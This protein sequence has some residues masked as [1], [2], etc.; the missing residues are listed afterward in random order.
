MSHKI[1][2][3][4]D[5]EAVCKDISRYLSTK[6]YDV[7]TANNGID[8]ISKASADKPDLILLD[9]NMPQMNGIECLRKI[10]ELNKD[11][12]VIMATV[13]TD[14][15]IAKEAINSGALDYITKPFDL[16]TLQAAIT[17]HLFLKKT[18]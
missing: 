16:D 9:I 3:V 17:T 15:D 14:I 1:L 18:E 11:A 2:V 5:E 10:K 8:A 6:G 7:V 12:L 4:D 13:A